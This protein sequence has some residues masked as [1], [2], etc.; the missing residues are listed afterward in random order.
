M[1]AQRHR[2][3]IAVLLQKPQTGNQPKHYPEEREMTTQ[4]L[5]EQGKRENE[6][7]AAETMQINLRNKNMEQKRANFQKGQLC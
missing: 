1:C 5:M 3:F 4:S 7:T 2:N 6:R